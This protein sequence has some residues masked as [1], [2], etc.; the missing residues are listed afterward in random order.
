MR[1]IEQSD[2]DHWHEHGFVI[3]EN[4]LS[5]EELAA[6]LRDFNRYM[7]EWDEFAARRP[8]YASLA[9]NSPQA[10]LG[11][12]RH[13][14]PYQGDELN[15]VAVHPFLVAFAERLLDRKEIA[16]SHG[17]IVGKYAGGA[18][19]DQE[20]HADFS[21]NTLAYPRSDPQYSDIPMIVYHTDVTVDL[22]PTYV[23]SKQHTRHL[24]PKAGRFYSRA[25]FPE[26]YA[27]EQPA[28]LPAGSALI[29]SMTTLHRG[30]AMTSQTGVR[31]SQ[32][33][34]FHAAGVP[35][36]GSASFQGAGGKPEMD[37]FLVN[38]SPRER[39][40]IGF[41][42]LGDPY[43][44]QESLAGVGARYPDMDLAPYRAAAPA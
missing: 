27:A 36:L 31:F 3:V 20:L 11:W 17:A 33:V 40:L 5:Q 32:F 9:A 13:E 12:V 18:D 41:P 35:W 22:G 10:S 6:G 44:N 24:P 25:Q 38:A 28:T 8:L 21:N 29:Y 2:I 39:Q 1:D 23:V 26:L 16:L 4:V 14:F 37:H 43:W 19:Y 34:A 7:P 42:A 30:S 15:A